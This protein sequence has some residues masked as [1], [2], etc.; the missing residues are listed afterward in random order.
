MYTNNVLA[1][2]N[3]T[4]QFSVANPYI[5]KVWFQFKDG[6]TRAQ[7]SGVTVLYDFVNNTPFPVDTVLFQPLSS[8]SDGTSYDSLT[9]PTTIDGPIASGTTGT[10]GWFPDDP[11][12]FSGEIQSI[13]A[14]MDGGHYEWTTIWTRYIPYDCYHVQFTALTNYLDHAPAR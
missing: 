9:S 1:S 11:A 13:A 5:N 12:S 6:R 8:V 2:Y 7:V 4:T 14:A 10:T 3:S